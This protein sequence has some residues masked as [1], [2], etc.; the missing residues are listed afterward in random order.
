MIFI[1]INMNKY[2]LYQILCHYYELLVEVV[3]NFY[4]LKWFTFYGKIS[5]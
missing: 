3:L 5:Q 1:D 2:F 4:K